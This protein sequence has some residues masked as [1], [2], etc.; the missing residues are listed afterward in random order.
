MKAG[1]NMIYYAN[2]N[3]SYIQHYG[4]L[5]MKWG[6][7]KTHGSNSYKSNKAYKK[8]EEYDT[9]IAKK[10]NPSVRNS[11]KRRKLYNKYDKKA[12]KDIKKAIK[13]DDIKSA[14]KISA[15]R[16]YAKMIVDSNYANMAISDC[17]KRAN[18]NIGKNF[19]YKI[20]KNNKLGGVNVNVNGH[21]ENYTYDPNKIFIAK[22]GGKK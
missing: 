19:T 13:N 11:M 4:V 18:V 16:T 5:G 3:S 9:K 7:R 8:L 1:V 20:T 6:H 14:L 15:N 22:T 2:E 21:T 12:N 10:K 17:A